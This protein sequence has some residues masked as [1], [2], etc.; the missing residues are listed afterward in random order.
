MR[1]GA[2]AAGLLLLAVFA[3]WLA[4]Q[5]WSPSIAAEPAES[6]AAKPGS[7]KPAPSR[8]SPQAAQAAPN[9]DTV[10]PSPVDVA[11]LSDNQRALVANNLAG[12]VALVSLKEGRVLSE[13]AVG[14]RPA[15]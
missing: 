9:Q 7:A 8:P 12:T 15:A 4:D 3:A 13:V 10:D 5:R 6:L 1:R 14:Q 11:L 2:P